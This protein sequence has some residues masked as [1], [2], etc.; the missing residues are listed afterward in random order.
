MKKISILILL[1]FLLY[2]CTPYNFALKRFSEIP[3]FGL[4][5]S[6]LGSVEIPSKYSGSIILKENARVALAIS[7]Q[8]QFISYFNVNIE[9]GAGL[10]FSFRTI[11]N[12]FE[13]H[14]SI[15]FKYDTYGSYIYNNKKLINSI[16][17]IKA[18]IG[19][20]KLISISNNGEYYQVTV[21]C[22]TVYKGRTKL[23][24]TEYVIIESLEGTKAYIS[25][26]EFAEIY[27]ID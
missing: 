19:K 21:D 22:D 17:S 10:I 9:K 1:L 16:D 18:Q 14:P 25:G 6:D 8:T 24:A 2:S 23:P 4:I 3:I 15:Q 7:N 11:S 5:M 13:S 27:D 12:S 26:I 20:Q